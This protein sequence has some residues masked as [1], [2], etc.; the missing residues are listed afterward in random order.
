MIGL[1]FAIG[2]VTLLIVAVLAI[3]HWP[4]AHCALHGHEPVCSIQDC[5]VIKFH[6]AHCKRE[7]EAE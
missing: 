4:R 7:C 6:C 1:A 2:I 5:G 3:G